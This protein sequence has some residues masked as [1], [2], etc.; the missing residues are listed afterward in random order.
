MYGHQGKLF[1]VDLTRGHIEE[2]VYSA[3]YAEMFPGGNGFAAKMIWDSVPVG[4][5]PLGPENAVV[6]TV[7]PLQTRLFGGQAAGTWPPS[8]RSPAFS[9]TPIMAASLLL[10]RRERV[11]TPFLSMG[12]LQNLCT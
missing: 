8:R 11:T 10:P 12:P 9:A 3:D 4:A 5:D 1:K 7:G 6:F 2:E